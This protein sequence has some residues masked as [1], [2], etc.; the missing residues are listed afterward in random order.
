MIDLKTK[1]NGIYY[2]D[3]Q[4]PAEGGGYKRQR[5]SLDTRDRKEADAQRRDWLAGVHPKHP[6][7]GGVVAPKGREARDETSVSSKT[8]QTDGPTVFQ[9]L[10]DCLYDPKVWR[11]AKAF[12]THQSN[13]KILS[14]LIG[15]KPMKELSSLDVHNLEKQLRDEFGYAEA[16]ICK[17][18]GTLSKACKVAA[19]PITGFLS[20][21]PQFPKRATFDNRQDR[22]VTMDEEAVMLECI[23]ARIEA[24]P[25][26]HWRAF[27]RLV[28][29]L[30]DTGCRLGEPIQSG[31]SHIKRKPGRDREGNVIQGVWFHIRKEITKNGR[32]RDVPLTARLKAMLPELNANAAG[33]RWFPWPHGS[34]GPLYLLTCIR[35][36]MKLRGF[37]FDDVKLH[38][39][40][41]TCATRLAEGGLDLIALR[42]W[43]GHTDIK[44]TAGRYVHLMNGHIYPGVSILDDYSGTIGSDEGNWDDD[45]SSCGITNDDANGRDRVTAGTPSV[46]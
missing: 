36:D 31:P 37:D 3:V 11:D 42:D 44:I 15:H 6:A 1:P 17:L 27:K 35:D 26:R 23:D 45:G 30:L 39:L 43:L 32:S 46:Q 33:G 41:H 9:W 22:V 13:V 10:T 19:Q 25:L 16:S 34:S 4:I 21:P 14:K 29:F 24:E 8:P 12:A 28:I 2:I 18:M 40:R 7:M 20:T 5:I 38:T